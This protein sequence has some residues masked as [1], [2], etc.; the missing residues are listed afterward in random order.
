M[1][2][3]RFDA[4]VTYVCLALLAYFGWH[5]YYGQRGY[6]YRDKLATQARLLS[7]RFTAI[8]DRRKKLEHR[9]S[10][11]RPDSIDPDLLDELA[12]AEL[13]VAAP[14]ELVV[15][16]DGQISQVIPAVQP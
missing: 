11:V 12:R 14:N 4:V 5:A 8:E 10:L 9:V 13:E 15:L 16:R 7:D 6:P 1:R 2:Q 3:R